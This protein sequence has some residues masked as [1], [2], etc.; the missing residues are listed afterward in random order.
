[1]IDDWHKGEAMLNALRRRLPE[2]RVD[3]T[4][5]RSTGDVP[6][7]A[8]TA[9][10]S[11]ALRERSSAYRDEASLN[12]QLIDALLRLDEPDAAARTLD[13]HRAN[14]EAMAHDLQVVVADAAVE[15]EAER[16]YA[17]YAA[18]LEQP[19]RGRPTPAAGR[20]H[21]RIVT[22]ASA[23]AVALALVVPTQRIWPRTTLASMDSS[24]VQD[25]L[26]TA[27]DRLDA[28]RSWAWALRADA[29]R[30]R[31][32]SARSRTADGVVRRHLRAIRTDE[33]QPA[34][35]R[36]A[37][38]APTDDEEASGVPSDLRNTNGGVA[39]GLPDGPPA[40]VIPLRPDADLPVESDE[41]PQIDEG[42]EA[43]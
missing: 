12:L 8:A 42:P 30:T 27:K 16:V 6:S 5:T 21:R 38:G 43:G 7:R 18:T 32:G 20:L 17:A 37:D 15:R 13:D 26:A 1:M 33:G 29:P 3:R 2:R 22:L 19:A 34:A 10:L 28:A 35:G 40:A 31:S 23:A 36:S 39:D 14:L 9:R 41:M 24:P 25:D 4:P 11:G